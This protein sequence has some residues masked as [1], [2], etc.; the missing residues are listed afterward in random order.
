MTDL[1]FI[2]TGHLAAFLVEG[3]RR[4]GA[5]YAITVS[6]RNRAMAEELRS[7]FGVAIAPDNQAVVDGCDVIVASVLPRQAGAVLTPLKFRRDQTVLSVMAGVG[8]L[9]VREHASPATVAVA[10]MP[11]HA[12]A[13]CVGPSALYPDV[14][15]ARALLRHLGP[16]HVY[17][18]EAIFTAASVFGA[19]SGMSLLLMKQAIDWFT[20]KGLDATDARTL[21]AE[22]IGGNAAVLRDSALGLDEIVAGVATPGGIT[23]QGWRVAGQGRHW[24]AAL[25]AVLRRLS[26]AE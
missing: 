15:A 26:Q 13:F 9:A 21:V 24:P 10:M 12:N 5:D 3:L 17:G 16:V 1:G 22:V 8:I 6:P 2:G 23:E 14:P 7:R 20:A 4:A 19:F 25:D 18:D 11:G